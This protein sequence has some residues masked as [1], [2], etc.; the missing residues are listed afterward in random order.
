MGP[1]LSERELL[2]RMRRTASRH[3]FLA[4]R[5]GQGLHGTVTPPA[6]QRNFL[7]NPAR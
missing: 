7:E 4:S 1:A 2:H 6:I 5:I 3:R